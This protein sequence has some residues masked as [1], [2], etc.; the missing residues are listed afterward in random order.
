M[1]RLPNKNVSKQTF[2]G[3][4]HES[5]EISKAIVKEVR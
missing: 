1:R 4:H 3:T 5:K 2:I